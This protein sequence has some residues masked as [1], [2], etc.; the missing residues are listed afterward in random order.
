M[1]VHCTQT[2]KQYTKKGIKVMNVAW[3]SS[4]ALAGT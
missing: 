1:N 2:Q 3:L 4:V